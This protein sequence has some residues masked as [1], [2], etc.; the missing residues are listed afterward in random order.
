MTQEELALD[1]L[2]GLG[3]YAREVL[4]L[5]RL[6]YHVTVKRRRNLAH[7]I[8]RRK[9]AFRDPMVCCDLVAMAWLGATRLSQIEP[10]LRRRPE[11][12][13]AFGLPR[14]CDHTTAHNFI[15]AFHVAH[16][17][18]LD[19]ANARLLREH[20]S[21]L[22]QRA[23]IL[24]LDLAERLVRRPGRRHDQGY[25]WAVA[26]CAGE[27]IAQELRADTTDVAALVADTLAAARRLL[28]AKPA[29]VRLSG[30]CASNEVLRALARQ[31]FHF[32]GIVPWAW[33]ATQRSAAPAPRRWTELGAGSRALDLGGSLAALGTR[34]WLRAILVERPAP[35]PG[36][37]R[38]RLAIATSLLREPVGAVVRLAAS[39]CRI[40]A[41]YGHPR[42]PLGDGKLPSS[43]PRGNAAWLR[44]ATIAM[45]ALRLFARHLGGEWTPSRL[46]A[47]LRVIPWDTGPTRR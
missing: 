30:S 11:L 36:L 39:M 16:L 28:R 47:S 3:W 37:R 26:F 46:H 10:H 23:P 15:N 9:S 41:F 5:E 33:A 34:H 18:Q 13:R 31:R 8:K 42:W 27:A 1:L 32:V 35:A 17:R 25:H 2:H 29:L 21:A 24:D 43:G 14:F 44:L 12:A 6:F 45:N 20:G 38:E 7:P 19:A 4:R 40:R 22:A